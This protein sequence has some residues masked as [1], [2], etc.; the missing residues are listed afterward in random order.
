MP[1]YNIDFTFW[2]EEF[3]IAKLDA[4]DAVHAKELAEEY[5]ENVYAPD[6]FEINGIQV[7]E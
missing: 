6:G 5:I 2:N 3:G 4:D 1:K 7:I